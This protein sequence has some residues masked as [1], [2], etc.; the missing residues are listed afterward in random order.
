MIDVLVVDDDE[1]F[2]E[3][4]VRSLAAGGVSAV[5][6]NGPFGTINR[7]RRERPALVILDVN[8]PAISGQ[9]VAKLIRSADGLQSIKLMLISS[10]EQPE[11]DM[12]KVELQADEAVTKTTDR[13][14]L[15]RIV[16]RLLNRES[17]PVR[18][19]SDLT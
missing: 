17:D 15:L 5:A 7:I 11:L 14:E 13:T 10:L 12:L 2:G 18:R 16:K 3:I 1:T 4:M 6:Q 19:R 8:M 9:N